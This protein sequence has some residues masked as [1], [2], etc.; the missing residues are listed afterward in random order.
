[1]EN[2][3]QL[4]SIGVVHVDENRYTI[5]LDRKFAP[6]LKNLDGFSHLQVVWWAHVT[7]SSQKRNRLV[8]EKLFKRG[9]DQMGVFATRSPFR[10]NPILISTI[11]VQRIDFDKGIISTPFIDAEDKTPVL[12]IK[13]YFSMQRVKHCQNPAWCQNWPQ[14]FEETMSFNWSDEIVR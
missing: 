10:P 8:L 9:P 14:W 5:Q 13:P 1:M 6:G 12:D 11:K 2:A 3:F 4:E 7:D